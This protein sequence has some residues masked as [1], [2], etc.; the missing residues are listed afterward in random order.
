MHLAQRHRQRQR[1][2]QGGK[3]ATYLP[4]AGEQIRENSSKF[5]RKFQT[6]TVSSKRD[7]LA[8]DAAFI[9]Q[10][11]WNVTGWLA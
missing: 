3:E 1:Q 6:K 7:S 9:A 8:L 4:L 2:R 5:S 11:Q 10:I